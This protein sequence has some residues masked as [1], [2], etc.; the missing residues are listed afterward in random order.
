MSN[1][2]IFLLTAYGI[3]TAIVQSKIAEPFRE[4][5]KYRSEFIYKLLNCM[6]CT[7]F[8]V[9]IL[10]SLFIPLTNFLFDGFFGLGGVWLLYMLQLYLEKKAGYKG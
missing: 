6:M 9:S 2:I 1:I 8:W 3:T 7:G 4:Y 10:V 5:F